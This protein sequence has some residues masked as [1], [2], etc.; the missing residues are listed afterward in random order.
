MSNFC[1]CACPIVCNNRR[2]IDFRPSASFSWH[3]SFH[4]LVVVAGLEQI[5]VCL[6]RRHPL[7]LHVLAVGPAMFWVSRFEVKPSRVEAMSHFGWAAE[8]HILKI[9][10]WWAPR[11]DP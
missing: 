6:H 3:R 10:R 5:Q 9:C 11:A 7:E 8:A 2:A 1:R 4:G